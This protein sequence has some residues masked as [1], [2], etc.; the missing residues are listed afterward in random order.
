MWSLLKL[1]SSEKM[2]TRLHKLLANEGLGSR[3][4]IEAKIKAGHIT[5]NGAPALIGQKVSLG[6]RVYVQSKR[7]YFTRKAQPVQVLL[8][9]KPEGEICDRV[10][11]KS[12][13]AK[14]PPLK[15]GRWVMVGRLD[16]NTSGLLLF[17]NYGQL[18]H[19][20]MHPRF[21]VP[22]RYAVRVL[23]NVTQEMISRLLKG[24]SLP[25]GFCRFHQ[26]VPSSQQTGA[27]QWFTCTLKEGKYR[28][29]RQLW[30]SQGC[31]VSRLIRIQ[32]GDIG[33][34]SSLKK[35]QYQMLSPNRVKTLLLHFSL[36]EELLTDKA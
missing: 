35:R 14:L 17:T 9:H 2:K 32:Y 1:H 3:R 19:C 36:S 10:S 20:L 30:A 33:L 6:D 12:V 26:I 22:R 15:S 18:A 11:E 28:E 16:V 21:Q 5:V 13:F 34:P 31:T 8:Y 25:E 29:V 27:N 4:A 7:I 24:I 23:G